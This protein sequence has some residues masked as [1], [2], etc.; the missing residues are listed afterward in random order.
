M[1]F[2]RNRKTCNL[3]SFSI[4]VLPIRCWCYLSLRD[5]R[6]PLAHSSH[7]TAIDFSFLFPYLI[8]EK[9]SFLYEATLVA[10]ADYFSSCFLQF[11][12][13]I[14]NFYLITD[15]LYTVLLHSLSP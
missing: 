11:N 15:K 9:Y 8:F 3:V 1:I 7:S 2:R 10:I 12:C 6:F 5:R 13:H 4:R 14:S